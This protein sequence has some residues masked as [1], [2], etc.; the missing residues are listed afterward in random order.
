[1]DAK[2]TKQ[3]ITYK[4]MRCLPTSTPSYIVWE[5]QDAAAVNEYIAY[6]KRKQ[7]DTLILYPNRKL[8]ASS[9]SMQKRT[10]SIHDTKRGF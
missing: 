5:Y 10:I 7:P 4:V 8:I 9:L 3:K 2:S 1:M 6:E